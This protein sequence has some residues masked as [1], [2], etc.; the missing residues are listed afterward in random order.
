MTASKG[1]VELEDPAP[2]VAVLVRSVV[3]E[4]S[5]SVALMPSPDEEL[6]AA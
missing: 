5:K 1:A 3:D 2:D 6:V 4:E